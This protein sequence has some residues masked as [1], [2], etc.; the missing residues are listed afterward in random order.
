MDSTLKYDYE[1]CISF[2]LPSHVFSRTHLFGQPHEQA[3]LAVHTTQ[4]GSKQSNGTYEDHD[5]CVCVLFRL[6]V[7][8]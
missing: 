6:R 2:L 5:V 8:Q 7:L 1:L 4:E 3:L